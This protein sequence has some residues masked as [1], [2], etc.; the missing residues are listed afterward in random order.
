MKVVNSNC[1]RKKRQQEI[2][3]NNSIYT[4]ATTEKKVG[5]HFIEALGNGA[6]LMLYSIS[7]G[8]TI[9]M[10]SGV[11]VLYQSASHTIFSYW[12]G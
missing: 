12:T 8:V 11:N 5:H 3:E 10:P 7:D 6:S 2:N 9:K 4:I 1:S